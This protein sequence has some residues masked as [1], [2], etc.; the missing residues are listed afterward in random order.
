MMAFIWAVVRPYALK[1]GLALAVVLT[2]L[3][4]LARVKQAGRTQERL[5]Q[6]N[7]QAKIRQRQEKAMSKS[8][9]T[10]KEIIAALEKGAF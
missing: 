9:R 3:A 5:E 2:I 4:V 10:K 1:I 7:K 6:A 8:P